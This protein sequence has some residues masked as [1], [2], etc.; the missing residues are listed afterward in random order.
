MKEAFSWRVAAVLGVAV[1][2]I[3]FNS[4]SLLGSEPA[5]AEC[6]A[7][8]DCTDTE[9]PSAPSAAPAVRSDDGT[10]P[11]RFM[12]LG[13]VTNNIDLERVVRFLKSCRKFVPESTDIVFMT[14][15]QSTGARAEV[16]REMRV[17]EYVFKK[18][19]EHG[20]HF[21]MGRWMMMRNYM[22]QVN[23]T[24]ARIMFADIRDSI[25]QADPFSFMTGFP[26]ADQA[27]YV[28]QEASPTKRGQTGTIDSEGK[29]RN[30]VIRCFGFDGLKKV[31]DGVVSCA[32]ITIGGWYAALKYID[33][34]SELI[35]SKPSCNDQGV[36][37]YII[38]S[39]DLER[40][41]KPYALKTLSLETGWILTV[42]QMIGETMLRDRSGTVLNRNGVPYAMVHQYDRSRAR[43]EPQYHEQFPLL[44]GK[45]LDVEI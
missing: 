21:N 39:G 38:Y 30:W 8:P 16:Y 12:I 4:A 6:P 23:G 29:N 32:G 22:H 44:E 27:L 31:K 10:V 14:D 9:C 37:N 5:P 7:H 15:Y 34:L 36:H 11:G 18:G 13:L 33:L 41:V 1:F 40:V 43:L 26:G 17:T 20:Y 25:C 35:L 24:Y 19:D 3:A 45:D 42:Q 2:Y 28:F